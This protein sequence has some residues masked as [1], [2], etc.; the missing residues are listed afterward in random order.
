MTP[1]ASTHEKTSKFPLDNQKW[2]APAS[3]T[4]WKV[5]LWHQN[6][7]WGWKWE[8]WVGGVQSCHS[9]TLQR[10]GEWEEGMTATRKQMSKLGEAE[11]R[12]GEAGGVGMSA[13]KDDSRRGPRWEGKKGRQERGQV[14]RK[15]CWC[16]AVALGVVEILQQRA[17]PLLSNVHLILQILHHENITNKNITFVIK[18]SSER[19]IRN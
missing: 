2:K 19:K 7:R 5:T 15:G 17:S 14:G 6:M 12:R 4:T 8:G 16:F 10:N 1:C 9:V 11:Q 13:L 18:S 3:E